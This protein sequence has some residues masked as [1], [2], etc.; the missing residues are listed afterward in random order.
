M[1]RL[2]REVVA[3]KRGHEHDERGLGE[4]EV[5]DEVVDTAQFGRWAQKQ[6]G[7]APVRVEHTVGV[8]GRFKRTHAGGPNR[9]DAVSARPCGIQLLR[10]V[11]CD[12]APLL[13][14]HMLRG[15]VITHR[16]EGAGTDM[17]QHVGKLN[18]APL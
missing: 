5:G 13:V 8:D 16:P 14:H 11:R 18:A 2:H 9:P 10:G 6:V 4:M 1:V 7:I 15:I 12:F 17:E 3:G